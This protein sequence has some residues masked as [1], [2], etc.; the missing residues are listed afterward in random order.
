MKKIV[1]AIAVAT[2]ALSLT[3]CIG[4][5]QEFA[6]DRTENRT[7]EVQITLKDGRTMECLH[8]GRGYGSLDCNWA[9]AK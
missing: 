3:G 6:E 2:L 9:G 1:T 5:K 8:Y 4:D 7:E